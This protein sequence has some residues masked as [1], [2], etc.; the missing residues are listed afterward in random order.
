M[1]YIKL[2][3]LK[4]GNNTPQVITKKPRNK[5]FKITLQR[6]KLCSLNHNSR[7]IIFTNDFNLRPNKFE[8]MAEDILKDVR[9]CGYKWKLFDWSEN[10]LVYLS[11]PEHLRNTVRDR[12]RTGIVS[13]PNDVL[14]ELDMPDVIPI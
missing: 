4:E 8:D 12:T 14:S 9:K 5:E 13:L 2:E 3:D 10:K 11:T 1:K 7:E 6:I